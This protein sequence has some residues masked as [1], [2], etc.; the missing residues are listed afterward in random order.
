MRD[1]RMRAYYLSFWETLSRPQLAEVLREKW[2]EFFGLWHE[3]RAGNE[4]WYIFLFL[5][6]ELLDAHK[7]GR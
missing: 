4:S 1:K 5:G 2:A 3:G 7:R 6:E